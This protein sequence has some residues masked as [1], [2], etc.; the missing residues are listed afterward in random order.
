MQRGFV[1]KR[2]T[3]WTAY[4]TDLSSD[5]RQRTKGGFRTKKE[6][7]AHL[8]EILGRLQRG[9][10]VEA[11]KLTFGAYLTD[12]WLPLAKRSVRQTTWDSYDRM[13]RNHVI[14]V[15]GGV[16]IQ[17]LT[18]SHLDGLY[19][20]L[21]TGGRKDGQ[22]GGLS[23]K[24]VRYLHTTLQKALRD[25]ERKQLVYRNV[26]QAADPP[27]PGSRSKEMRTWSAEEVG[28]FLTTMAEHRLSAAYLLAASTGMRRGEILG[29]RW[30]DVDFVTGRVA[31]RQT[32]T[33]VNY[34]IIVG[35]PKTS[36][37]RR[38]IAIDS[39]TAKAL[40]DHR[41]RQQSERKAMGE[42]FKDQDL[43]FCRPDGSPIHPDYFSQTFDRTVARVGLRRIRLHDLRHTHATLGL[44][45]GVP[46]KV[47]SD[48]LGHATVAFTQDV[49]MHAIPQLEADAADQIADLIFSERTNVVPFPLTQIDDHE[50]IDEGSGSIDG[51]IAGWSSGSS[52]GS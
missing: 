52:L 44:A 45:A 48:R 43:V 9:E 27:K 8:A 30:R 42:G 18:A 23:A 41:K 15:I 46:A 1:R 39:T 13:L 4:W 47:M 33:S 17:D 20:D 16:P 5:R 49:Y 37:G 11:S 29:L 12:Q 50:K 21:L 31:V 22:E 7:L 2:G 36:R 40:R 19:T 28:I 38:S 10:V 51:L 35:E 26:A 32:I 6:A 25:A 34:E 3:T 14:P 24:T